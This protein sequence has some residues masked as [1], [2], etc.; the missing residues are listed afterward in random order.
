MVVQGNPCPTCLGE[1]R[2]AILLKSDPIGG[3]LL[4][5]SLVS[6]ILVAPSARHRI[7]TSSILT[8]SNET[9]AP[10]CEKVPVPVSTK[11]NLR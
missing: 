4:I 7:Q 5:L 1:C 11:P 8:I 9:A 2:E 10:P 6:A 3:F